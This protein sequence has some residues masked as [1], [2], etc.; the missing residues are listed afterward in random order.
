MAM[1]DIIK[2][3]II[4]G[5]FKVMAIFVPNSLSTSNLESENSCMEYKLNVDEKS[6]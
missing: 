4:V 1:L 3:M 2:A 6:G 5:F